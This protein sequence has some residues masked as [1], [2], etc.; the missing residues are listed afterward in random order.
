MLLGNAAV[1]S[2]VFRKR[3]FAVVTAP[4]LAVVAVAAARMNSPNPLSVNAGADITVD[5]GETSSSLEA[6]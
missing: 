4:M 5:I 6:R 3:A 2:P 1:F